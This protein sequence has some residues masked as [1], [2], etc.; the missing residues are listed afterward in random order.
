V[1]IILTADASSGSS[2]SNTSSVGSLSQQQ[3]KDLKKHS[4]ANRSAYMAAFPK[5]PPNLDEILIRF[6][7]DG[8]NLF[9]DL[10]L[11]HLFFY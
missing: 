1:Y 11:Y 6:E 7:G 2:L 8:L 10:Y 3:I 9:T 4:E 5:I